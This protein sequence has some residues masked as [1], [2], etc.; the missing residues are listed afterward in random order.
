VRDGGLSIDCGDAFRNG[1]DTIQFNRAL[2]SNEI[3]ENETQQEK[4]NEPLIEA[5]LL[6]RVLIQLESMLNMTQTTVTEWLCGFPSLHST[7]ILPTF[8]ENCPRIESNLT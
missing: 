5:I 2:N 6:T 4:P 7:Q 8:V 1:H 3:D